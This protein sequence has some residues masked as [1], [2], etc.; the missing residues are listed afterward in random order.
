MRDKACFNLHDIVD[1]NIES[2]K[3]LCGLLK[4]ENFAAFNTIHS[5]LDFYLRNYKAV[6]LV[7]ALKDIPIRIYGS[8][9][10][11]VKRD[12]NPNH[13]F[14]PGLNAAESQVLFYSEYGILDVSPF[15]GLHDRSIRAMANRTSFLSNACMDGSFPDLE[16]YS[17]LF[18][19][20]VG[21]DLRG[22]ASAIMD[23]PGAHRDLALDFSKRFRERYPGSG[24]VATMAQFA[25]VH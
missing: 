24:F 20:F 15:K 25:R 23:N 8:G 10:E 9:W 1:A 6:S 5:Q 14:R 11:N 21:D 3:D 16:K 18:Y 2:S 12:N 4:P 17:A 7:K 19:S 13:E 22:R